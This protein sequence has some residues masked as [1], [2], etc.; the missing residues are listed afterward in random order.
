MKQ[1]LPLLGF[2]PVLLAP[3]PSALLNAER[4]ECDERQG[5]GGGRLAVGSGAYCRRWSIS[6]HAEIASF[7]TYDYVAAT[8][9]VLAGRQ[10]KAEE[11]ARE[12]QGDAE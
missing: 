10:L 2:F 1:P 5:A 11:V 4:R 8:R 7:L 3:E 12:I 9:E 6:R